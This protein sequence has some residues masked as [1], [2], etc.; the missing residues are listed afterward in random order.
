MWRLAL[1][2]VL[3]AGVQTAWG[4]DAY[5]AWPP[6]NSV[7]PPAAYPPGP[8]M[9]QDI[10]APGRLQPAS[11]PASPSGAA[12][13]PPGE[14]LRRTPNVNRQDWLNS[15]PPAA[16]STVMAVPATPEKTT[17]S[18]W[19]F[20]QDSYFWNERVGGADIVKE[21]G[22]LS[23]LGYQR[24]V[25]IERFRIEL[26]GGSV[27]YDGSAEF[28][29][30]ASQSYYDVPYHLSYGTNYLGCRGE[31]DLLIEPA[32]WSRLRGIVGIGTRFWVRDLQ[33][34]SL[35]AGDVTGYQ[36]NWWTF[37]P[38]IGLETKDSLEP[39]MKFFGSARIGM[40]A[41]TYQYATY[42]DTAVYP[43][44]GVTGQLELGVRFQK[45]SLSAFF[46]AMTW[47]ESAAVTDAFGNASYQP[48][49]RMLTIG[50]KLSY[51]F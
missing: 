27:A 14:D 23:T 4:D 19:Y 5:L 1:T 43:R 22:P 21:Y 28:Y 36:E 32:G 47:A 34:T 24:R 49:S 29:D 40:T 15:P 17:D 2:I 25:G 35:A 37:Y 3:I 41:L 48:E 9:G 6:A 50:G 39:G 33:S 12:W 13:P 10:A 7:P 30:Q 46:E 51:T 38:Y 16:A 45:F 8:P 31:Y 44:C 18:T 20:R 42:F 26:F 11:A